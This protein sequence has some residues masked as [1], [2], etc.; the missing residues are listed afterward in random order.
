MILKRI[1]KMY[2]TKIE[3][4]EVK[5][6][7]NSSFSIKNKSADRADLKKGENKQIDL[8]EGQKELNTTILITDENTFDNIFKI[9]SKKRVVKFTDK[10]IGEFKAFVKSFEV[11]NSDKHLNLTKINLQLKINENFNPKINYKGNILSNISKLESLNKLDYVDIKNNLYNPIQSIS[12]LNNLNPKN[13]FELD[14]QNKMKEFNSYI[15]KIEQIVKLAYRINYYVKNPKVFK[16]DLMSS[17][18]KAIF[19]N[20]NLN[21]IYV[22]NLYI[23]YHL[24]TLLNV[25]NIYKLNNIKDVLLGLLD[26]NIELNNNTIK[27]F[28]LINFNS[29]KNDIIN[30]VSSSDYQNMQL[31]EFNKYTN[32]QQWIY[33]YYGN[34]DN[35]EELKF[36]NK[37]HIDLYIGKFKYFEKV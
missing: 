11:V 28:T 30:F 35:V 32:L 26:S 12:N 31:V 15:D 25:D 1:N 36:I 10:F 19:S 4:I 17:L 2:I 20:L 5:Q 21:S 23:K 9:L 24:N 34:L 37:T 22:N 13:V 16:I 29:M 14:L 33:K 18:N 7:N 27:P 3:N 6:D 8:G